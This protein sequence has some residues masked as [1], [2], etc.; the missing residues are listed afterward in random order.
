MRFTTTLE[1]VSS[2]KS[3]TTIKLS[4]SNSAARAFTANYLNSI[5]KE[6]VVEISDPQMEMDL[7]PTKRGGIVATIDSNGTVDRVT[8]ELAD[9]DEAAEE[10]AD[11][12][13]VLVQDGEE[14]GEQTEVDFEDDPNHDPEPED[15]DNQ[16]P[17]PDVDPAADA[18]PE[19]DPAGEVDPQELKRY[20]LSVRPRWD[21]I[22]YDFPE[23]L[24]RKDAEGLKWHDLSG[25]LKI[26]STVLQAAY[27]KYKKRCKE[28]M[29][30]GAA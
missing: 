24:E 26:P 30:N 3:K 18:D 5:D 27:G 10:A 14:D 20:I 29:L 9:E 7:Q 23:M 2:N 13:G 21:D 4:L 16:D 12:E 1:A 22:P 17:E 8:R 15:D 28:Q 25:E 19:G 6:L 11:A